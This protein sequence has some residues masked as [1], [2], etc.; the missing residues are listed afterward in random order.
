MFDRMKNNIKFLF[1]SYCD[2]EQILYCLS[3]GGTTYCKK[4]NNIV[5]KPIKPKE[6][7]ET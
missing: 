2:I 7:E 4:T 5:K 1:C 6:S 3:I